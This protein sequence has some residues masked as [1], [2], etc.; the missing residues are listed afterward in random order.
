MQ[1]ITPTPPLLPPPCLCEWCTERRPHS[2]MDWERH[3]NRGNRRGSKDGSGHTPPALRVSMTPR[4][5]P[6]KIPAHPAFR[7]PRACHPACGTACT[8]WHAKGGGAQGSCMGDERGH[9]H[10]PF[11]LLCDHFPTVARNRGGGAAIGRAWRMRAPP[12]RRRGRH[13]PPPTPRALPFAQASSDRRDTPACPPL[14]GLCNP[15]CTQAGTVT[16]PG[17]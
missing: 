10:T 2:G 3:A 15:L 16:T 14:C 12:C 9:A 13:T 11:P 6:Y 17:P 8:R 4:C 5:P 7:V 1:G